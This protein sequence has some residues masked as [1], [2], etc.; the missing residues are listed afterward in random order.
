[1]KA[2]T[3]KR[4]KVIVISLV[5]IAFVL[6]Y[7]YLKPPAQQAIKNQTNTSETVPTIDNLSNTSPQVE[8][9]EK[10]E[11]HSELRID[12][13]ISSKDLCYVEGD[14]KEGWLIGAIDKKS[15]NDFKEEYDISSSII[16][17]V[18]GYFQ[19]QGKKVKV[20]EQ[21]INNIKDK[22]ETFSH[23]IRDVAINKL[24][25]NVSKFEFVTLKNINGSWFW[26]YAVSNVGTNFP[27]GD[28]KVILSFDLSE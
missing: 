24:G 14:T 19:D 8:E 18:D 26:Q 1:M 17:I 9:T 2:K 28:K 13:L 22:L 20:S 16:T 15:V 6:L 4:I 25:E 23:K 21:D 3:K 12:C 10:P 27:D 5:I 7:V 11:F